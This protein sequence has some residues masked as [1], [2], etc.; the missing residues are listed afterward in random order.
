MKLALLDAPMNAFFADGGGRRKRVFP[1]ATH[2]TDS[3]AEARLPRS[4][5]KLLL[6]AI[7][8][9]L[10]PTLPGKLAFAQQ[11]PASAVQ[12]T[13]PT[14]RIGLDLD[15]SSIIAD[16]TA[17]LARDMVD[18]A[19]T[20]EARDAA[21]RR[22]LSIGTAEARSAVQAALRDPGNNPARLA[23]ARAIA[24]D[25][26]ADAEFIDGLFVLLESDVP[27]PI[28][29]A[30]VQAMGNYKLEPDV[31]R[32]L[33]ELSKPARS[34]AQR[35][36]AIRALGSQIEKRAA[37]QLVALTQDRSPTIAAA[38][39][40][41]VRAFASMPLG[42]PTDWWRTQADHP[43]DRFRLETLAARSARSESE[44]RKGEETLAELRRSVVS[45]IT[46]AP[47][48]QRAATLVKFLRSPREAV[49]QIAAGQAYD[50]A[51]TGDLPDEARPVL[52]ELISDTDAEVRRS[53]AHTAWQPLVD[54]GALP[55]IVRQVAVEP[56]PR[57]RLE[58]ASAMGVIGNPQAVPL[59]RWLLDDA[60]PQVM[61]AAAG[62]I[63]KLAPQIA[64]TDPTAAAELAIRLQAV[65]Q[66]RASADPQ[67]R[68]RLLEALVPLRQPSMMATFQAI[69]T[70][71][72]R[73]PETVRAIAA[74]GLGA[75]GSANVAPVLVDAMRD[76]D[77]SATVRGEAARALG[78]VSNTFEYA[79]SIYRAMLAETDPR[80]VEIEWSTIKS[81]LP[82][83]PKQQ[84][85]RWTTLPQIAGNDLRLIDL[86]TE[87]ER[88]SA[89][90]GKFDE[91]TYYLQQLGDAS[92]RLGEIAEKK[93]D[94]AAARSRFNDA[95]A[96]YERALALTREKGL[97]RQSIPTYIVNTV[98]SQLRAR[99]YAGAAAFASNEFRGPGGKEMQGYI[100][101]E[102]KLEA[103]RLADANGANQLDDAQALIKEA[104]GMSPAL[105]DMYRGHLVEVQQDIERRRRERNEYAWPEYMPM[106]AMLR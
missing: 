17:S 79:E 50:F 61:T 100:G 73:E 6:V 18:P 2:Q 93:P 41:A 13:A 82:K 32:R 48:E 98:K 19:S 31:S 26:P 99:D 65:L 67:L 106:F 29:D 101:P 37:E 89:D 47:R 28:T 54:A 94:P 103:E 12:T 70:A 16:Q 95:T 38:A 45:E 20:Q 77:G 59:L 57:V 49:R 3:S 84:L 80:V 69:L 34:E 60:S 55:A 36:A 63:V 30:A 96:R 88:R 39:T 68:E 71:N 64:Q 23:A 35:L 72:P 11:E 27:K 105:A 78:S 42:S 53:A 66:T 46:A 90:A 40:E 1:Q 44:N 51:T 33:V 104:L 43:E 14:T 25:L 22:L 83:A 86:Y 24:D 102:F 4:K 62:S 7:A 58:L 91:E 5:N 81:L 21:A 75:I 9:C 92:M 15:P 87:L 56:D 52:R 74:R 8:A 85:D 76:Q 10:A 97:S